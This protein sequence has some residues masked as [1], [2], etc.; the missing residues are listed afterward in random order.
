[1]C[2]RYIIWIDLAKQPKLWNKIFLEVHTLKNLYKNET[3]SY[4]LVPFTFIVAQR[5]KK[6]TYILQRTVPWK[7]AT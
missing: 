6:P 7:F 2:F 3:S 5:Y 4:L 1:M